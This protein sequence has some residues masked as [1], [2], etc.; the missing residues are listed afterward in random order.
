MKINYQIEMEKIIK[1]L[2]SR[3]KLLLHS[4][5]APCSSAVIERLTENFE[6]TI[7]Y[8][9]P[10][11]EPESEYIKRLE[12]QKRL[13]SVADFA[14]GIKLISSEYDNDGFRS[15]VRGME[16][17]PEGGVRCRECIRI[18]MGSSALKALELECEFFTTTLSVSPHKNAEYI[19]QIG[20]DLEEKYKVKYLYSDFKKKEGYKRSIVLS[21]TYGLYRQEYCGCL[22][23]KKNTE[24]I[25]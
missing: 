21:Q 18:R 15:A 3:P 4:C 13:L 17:E 7:Y 1:G 2:N 19:N 14:K 9:N 23:A 5:C 22:F 6:L 10:N 24:E 12:E 25:D 8:Y 11:I 20:R 16:K